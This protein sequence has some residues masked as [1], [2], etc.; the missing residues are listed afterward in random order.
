MKK[1]MFSKKEITWIIITIIILAF[2]IGFIT[3]PQS[4]SA[5]ITIIMP[6]TASILII[7][8]TTIAKKIAAPYFSIRIEHKVWEFQR[9]GVY[10]RS[11]FKKPFPIG[12]VLPF[13]LTLLSLGYI[14]PMTLLQFDVE[15]I[16]ETRLLKRRGHTRAL[17]KQEMND[18]D[19]ALTAAW[20]FYALLILAILSS[21][22]SILTNL[23]FFSEI[24]KYSVFYGIWNLL[25]I[26]QLDGSKLFFGSILSWTILVILYIISLGLVI[27]F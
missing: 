17:R 24:T 23:N 22:I 7:L 12:L 27:I 2:I 5:K 10:E 1:E 26:S 18:A 21:I 25:P 20:G 4:E 13:F 11:H 9:Y 16:P 6:L 15:N 14:K 8:T 3:E 19:P